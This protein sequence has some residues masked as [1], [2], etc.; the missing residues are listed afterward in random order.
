MPLA[1]LSRL[2]HEFENARD[3]NSRCTSTRRQKA[4]PGRGSLAA[5]VDQFPSSFW[6]TPRPREFGISELPLLPNRSMKNVSFDSRLL[7]P[8]TVLVTV[9]VG[10]PGANVS[11]PVLA[12]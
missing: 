8:S 7:S 12:T 11:V 2:P 10:S 1:T 4:V 5:F 3:G 9:F 6:M